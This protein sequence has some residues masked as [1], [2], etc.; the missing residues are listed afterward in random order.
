MPDT[1]N[2][3]SQF[4][5]LLIPW[6]GLAEQED[7]SKI[8]KALVVSTAAEVTDIEPAFIL[9]P[10]LAGHLLK[11]PLSAAV[12]DAEFLTSAMIRTVNEAALYA[13]N[14]L[15]A[16][17]TSR[18]LSLPYVRGIG[19][20]GLN[21]GVTTFIDGVPQFHTSSANLSLLDV[22]QI[23]F[24]RGPVGTM[25][26][27]NTVGGGIHITSNQPSR[28]T[29]GGKFQTTLG[30]YNLW[31][32]RGSLSGPLIQDH[33][34]FSL[35]AGLSERDGYSKNTLTG[36]DADTRS[37][38]FGKA[39]FLWA[40]DES[41]E[42]RLIVA[43]ESDRDG[44][45][46]FTD[47]KALRKR[48]HETQQD[49]RG[50]S[51]RD[52]IMPTLEVIYHADAVDFTSTTAYVG[53]KTDEAS[54]LDYTATPLVTQLNQE[55][56]RTW[57]Q[58]FRFANPLNETITLNEELKLSWQAGLML[59]HNDYRQNIQNSFPA[60]PIPYPRSTQ[61]ELTQLGIGSY[62][63]GTL[64]W[65]ERLS[66]T[67]GLRWDHEKKEVHSQTSVISFVS[68]ARQLRANQLFN[69]LTP[70]MALSYQMSPS[71]MTYLS[72]ASGYKA[73]GFNNVGPAE[74]DEE[75]SRS[76]EIGLKSHSLKN[77]L[78]FAAAAF[79]TDWQNLQIT[80]SISPSLIAYKNAGKATSRG[81]ETSLTLRLSSRMTFFGSASWQATELA[82]STLKSD[83]PVGNTPLPYAPE[84]GFALGTL[85]NQPLSAKLSLYARVD[86]QTL[87]SFQY[88]VQ[89]SLT[90]DAYTLAN[91][92]LGLRQNAWFVEAFTNNAFNADYI[93]ITSTNNVGE[94]GAP[95]TVGMRA[96]VWF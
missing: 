17:S 19:G 89:N 88:D 68:P 59:F 36:Q 77:K 95:L 96:G 93:P 56:M 24:T 69:Q 30:N 81:L 53:W 1:R 20:S 57:T 70:Q 37:A 94:N 11:L 62:T 23:D 67:A 26:G 74:Y 73:G 45:P 29:F 38:K 91:F 75:R 42:V 4:L 82:K 21:P 72:L 43:G 55:Q 58:E 10:K 22:T 32:F 48:P 79:F 87:G 33:L 60:I 80:Q 15:F 76:Y 46:V 50:Y 7:E 41:L 47:L 49:F 5:T 2:F 90:Q 63:Q 51:S 86:I 61:T 85:F 92:R 18:R 8:P 27:R 34:G 25:F 28:T 14:T 16:E 84:Y 44:G 9:A 66:L 13:P 6:L 39:Q 83:V 65:K 12:T 3:L 54:D 52:V 71:L 64:T 40:P 78:S 31:D 35:A